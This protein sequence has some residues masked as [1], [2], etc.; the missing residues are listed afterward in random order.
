L[1]FYA[2]VQDERPVFGSRRVNAQVI[3][4]SVIPNLLEAGH[5][6]PVVQMFVGHKYPS[7][8]EKYR[9]EGVETLK[10]AVGKYHPF[11][12]GILNQ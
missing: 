11:E 12:A 5:E 9:Q 3:R 2:K 4:Q 1:L 7:S 8:T 10:A 6:S